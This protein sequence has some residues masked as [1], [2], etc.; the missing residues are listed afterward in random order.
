MPEIEKV[1]MPL[2]LAAIAI[3]T[4]IAVLLFALVGSQNDEGAGSFQDGGSSA[5]ELTPSSTNESTAERGVAFFERDGEGGVFFEKPGPL[6][7][8]SVK[9]YAWIGVENTGNRDALNGTEMV[10]VLKDRASNELKK[11]VSRIERDVSSGETVSVGASFVLDD[12]EYRRVFSVEVFPGSE[13]SWVDVDSFRGSDLE[14]KVSEAKKEFEETLEQQEVSRL[15]EG[16]LPGFY[17]D[18]VLIGTKASEASEKAVLKDMPGITLE[19]GAAQTGS[20]AARWIAGNLGYKRYVVDVG[21]SEQNGMSV[22]EAESIVDSIP[23]GAVLVFVT[24]LAG[25]ENKVDCSMTN[26]AIKTASQG[27]DFVDVMDWEWV[28]FG[29]GNLVDWHT[30]LPNSDEGKTA[31]AETLRSVLDSRA[32]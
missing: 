9:M 31:F 10:F 14:G 18:T 11:A 19:L 25:Q 21:G 30:G 3:L 29:N 17:E 20:E 28:S 24:Q 7:Q 2:L 16:F 23:T 4:A 13:Q 12:V 5:V 22:E 8:G 15:N 27:R 32:M 1:N 26:A 6:E